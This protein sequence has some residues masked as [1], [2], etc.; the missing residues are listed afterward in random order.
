MILIRGTKTPQ[1]PFN[2]NLPDPDFLL[3][4]ESSPSPTSFIGE[5]QSVCRGWSHCATDF[6]IKRR[7]DA[8]LVL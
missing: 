2:D 1:V 7:R 3:T 5:L 6:L 4:Y 8:K